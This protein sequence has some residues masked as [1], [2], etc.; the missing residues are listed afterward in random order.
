[1]RKAYHGRI[2]FDDTT[3]DDLQA[4]NVNERAANWLKRRT[5]A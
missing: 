5:A 2:S 4:I 1:M 3:A